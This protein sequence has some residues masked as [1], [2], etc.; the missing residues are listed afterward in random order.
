MFHSWNKKKLTKIIL[1][2]LLTLKAMNAGALAFY[3]LTK[4]ASRGLDNHIVLL[5]FL[6]EQKQQQAE[7]ICKKIQNNV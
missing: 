4:H 6:V 7:M 2:K 3:K 1:A 5:D